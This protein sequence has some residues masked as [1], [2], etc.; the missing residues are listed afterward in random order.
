MLLTDENRLAS[1]SCLF[2]TTK[3]VACSAAY[4]MLAKNRQNRYL[5]ADFYEFMIICRSL[6]LNILARGP[7]GEGGGE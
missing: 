5:A 1:L 4:D 2:L 3:T 6:T 7:K